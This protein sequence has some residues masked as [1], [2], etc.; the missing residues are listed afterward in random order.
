MAA[1][2]ARDCVSFF[3]GLSHGHELGS[4]LSIF[5]HY[6]D[7]RAISRLLHG[8]PARPAP[9]AVLPWPWGY[10]ALYPQRVVGLRWRVVPIIGAGQC[11]AVAY[12]A[13]GNRSESEAVN[14][15]V[16]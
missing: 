10:A 15:S 12:D 1:G 11:Q 14:V 2:H 13:A 9:E 7:R 16:R 8:H 3:Y 4:R 6:H 5:G